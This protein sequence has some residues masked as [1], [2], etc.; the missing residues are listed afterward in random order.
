MSIINIPFLSQGLYLQLVMVED[1]VT[2]CS[3]FLSNQYN[4]ISLCFKDCSFKCLKEAN[5][6]LWLGFLKNN[7]RIAEMR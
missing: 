2:K 5:K 3:N 7:L 4:E 6:S 1:D